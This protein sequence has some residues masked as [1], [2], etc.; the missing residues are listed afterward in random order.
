[1]CAPGNTKKEIDF[2]VKLFSEGIKDFLKL[3]KIENISSENFT[4][5]IVSTEE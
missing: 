3:P 5:I 1:M 4:A 2:S